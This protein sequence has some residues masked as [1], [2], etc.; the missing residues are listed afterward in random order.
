MHTH[1]H[2][3]ITIVEA[4]TYYYIT[5]TKNENVCLGMLTVI[6]HVIAEHI[7]TGQSTVFQTSADSE[8]RTR[9]SANN[10][11]AISNFSQGYQTD[12]QIFY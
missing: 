4:F 1:T 8:K 12:R 3:V 2:D 9:L 11:Y 10:N 7:N 6:A 5:L